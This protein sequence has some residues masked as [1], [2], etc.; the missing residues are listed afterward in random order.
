MYRSSGSARIISMDR[1]ITWHYHYDITTLHVICHLLFAIYFV[2]LIR[3][4]GIIQSCR[5]AVLIQWCWFFAWIL[6][7][8]LR[9]IGWW[10]CVCV[11]KFVWSRFPLLQSFWR[12]MAMNGAAHFQQGNKIYFISICGCDLPEVG[13]TWTWTATGTWIWIIC[14]LPTLMTVESAESC[15]FCVT[16]LWGWSSI[17][18][19]LIFPWFGI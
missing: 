3:V 11:S 16:S 15:V 5:V 1:H 10:C 7:G 9:L 8:H 14:H 12:S 13:N 19:T 17:G 4:A 2:S 6:M 18:D